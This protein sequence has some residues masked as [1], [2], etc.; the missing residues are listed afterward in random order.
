MIAVCFQSEQ[1]FIDEIER[2][3]GKIERDAGEKG[4][5]DGIDRNIVRL[6]S[7]QEPSGL[8]LVQR[9]FLVG[10]Y[11]TAGQMVRLKRYY[12]ELLGDR[13]RDAELVKQS[14]SAY[15]AISARCSKSSLELRSGVL[16]SISEENEQGKLLEDIKLLYL[17]FI[18]RVLLDTPKTHDLQMELATAFAERTLAL[19]KGC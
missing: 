9:L 3:A 18:P 10:S 15:D 4:E 6:T 7:V 8:G 14:I 19:M 11:S 17:S 2:D 13:E 1:E 12:G 5:T 16:E